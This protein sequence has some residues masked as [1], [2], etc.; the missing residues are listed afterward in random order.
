[1]AKQI[2][3]QELAAP[4]TPAPTSRNPVTRSSAATLRGGRTG[5]GSR[6]RGGSI[7]VLSRRITKEENKKVPTKEDQE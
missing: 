1:L 7:S 5:T 6:G 2:E 4:P 3:A